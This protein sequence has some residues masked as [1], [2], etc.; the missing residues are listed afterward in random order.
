MCPVPLHTPHSPLPAVL[1]HHPIKTTYKGEHNMA[2]TTHLP[3]AFFCL[4]TVACTKTNTQ[5]PTTPPPST[6]HLSL[7]H[8]LT[9]AAPAES[10]DETAAQSWCCAD[11][12]GPAVHA[13]C[14]ST[15]SPAS[16]QHFHSQKVSSQTK[17]EGP[18]L[19]SPV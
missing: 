8:T 2:A 14:P 10:A 19:Q 15:A 12:S 3:C 16:G 6:H 5:Y 7:W 9:P 11:C 1:Q 18:A 13:P 17:R 4:L